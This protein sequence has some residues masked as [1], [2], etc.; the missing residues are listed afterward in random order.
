ML[1]LSPKSC[2]IYATWDYCYSDCGFCSVLLTAMQ[3]SCLHLAVICVVRSFFLFLFLFLLLHFHIV[4]NSSVIPRIQI[5]VIYCNKKQTNHHHHRHHHHHHQQQSNNN[6]NNNNNN[7]KATI[8]TTTT[9]TTTITKILKYS[10]QA[11]YEI[12]SDCC[13][14]ISFHCGFVAVVVVVVVVVLFLVFAVV[15]RQEA[16]YEEVREEKDYI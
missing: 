5:K 14:N 4:L 3:E 7:N 8:T 16:R 2:L 9:T 1:L 12:N 10:I 15:A 11:C 6:N 13:E